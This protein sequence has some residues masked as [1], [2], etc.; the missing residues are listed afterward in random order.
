M[1]H[2]L[3]SKPHSENIDKRYFVFIYLNELKRN[4][5]IHHRYPICISDALHH[6]RKSYVWS[7]DPGHYV[8]RG[9]P[10]V[11]TT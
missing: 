2:K 5:F 11:G 6:T 3:C 4:R 8:R 1:Q 7:S 10:W 9:H